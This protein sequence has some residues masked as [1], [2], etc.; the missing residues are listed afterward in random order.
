MSGGQVR[1]I[2]VF[3]RMAS[4]ALSKNALFVWDQIILGLL[5]AKNVTIWKGLPWDEIKEYSKNKEWGREGAQ[6][7]KQVCYV[8][9][10]CEP[11]RSA[12]SEAFDLLVLQIK[13]FFWSFNWAVTVTS[14]P[15]WLSR[16][17]SA[18]NAEDAGNMGLI[19]GSGR[20]PGGGNGNPLQSSCLGNPTDRGAWWATVH[21]VTKS[22]TWLK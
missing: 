5:V 4:W 7:C 11:L 2:Q 8:L 13:E 10:S 17:E 3:S 22:Q 19:P 16:K 20:C 6:A 9:L 1:S 21:G 15:R 14:L 12:T 18:C